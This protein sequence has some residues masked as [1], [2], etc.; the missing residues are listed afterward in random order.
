MYVDLFLKNNQTQC[1]RGNLIDSISLYTFYFHRNFSLKVKQLDIPY[2]SY[3]IS[4]KIKTFKF[5]Y[6]VKHR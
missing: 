1:S 4:S 3:I 6:T 5:T 2:L